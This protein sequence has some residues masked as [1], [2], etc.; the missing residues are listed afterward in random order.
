MKALFYTA[1]ALVLCGVGVIAYDSDRLE[2]S[3]ELVLLS[4][5][6]MALNT[7]GSST[8]Y[9]RS[10]GRAASGTFANCS[11]ENCPGGQKKYIHAYYRCYSCVS[12]DRGIYKVS[13]Y[14]TE[15]TWCDK[16]GN[17][18]CKSRVSHLDQQ[19]HCKQGGPT[20]S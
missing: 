9:T 14:K 7:G 18:D 16:A 19:T 2:M 6:D 13:D 1:I 5:S 4:D 11:P 10:L 17:A 8:L 15:Y 12:G 3:D 20:C